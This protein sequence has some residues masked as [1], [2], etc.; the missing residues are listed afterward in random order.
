MIAGWS[1]ASRDESGGTAGTWACQDCSR[2]MPG[3]TAPGLDLRE[4]AGG[5]GGL[6]EASTPE[7]LRA[8]AFHTRGLSSAPKPPG[9]GL[10]DSAN[11]AFRSCCRYGLEAGVGLLPS[12]WVRSPRGGKIGYPRI[13]ERQCMAA[14]RA[15]APFSLIH[16]DL[17][18]S[19]RDATTRHA[20]AMLLPNAF[21]TLTPNSPLETRT[22]EVTSRRSGH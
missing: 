6:A 9:P 18:L 12:L 5:W 21:E 3:T 15:R 2:A 10:L 16:S 8:E 20:P 19:S 11:S 17:D 1:S 13:T 7:L 14:A 22:T 4:E